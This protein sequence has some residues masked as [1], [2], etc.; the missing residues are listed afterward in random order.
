[1]PFSET[2]SCGCSTVR[3]ARYW[4]TT[5]VSERRSQVI[6]AVRLLF[7]RAQLRHVLLLCP[8]SLITN[9]EAEF[10]KWAPE[11]GV[12]VLS[13]SVGLREDA[14]RVVAQRRHVIL[15]NYE[16][17]R[18]PPKTLKANPP[19]L[20][21]ADEAHRLRK[22]SAKA[23]AGVR[24]L[25]PKRFWALTGTPMERDTDDLA[26][27]LSLV[28]PKRFSAR[29]AHLHPSSLR[30]QARPYVLRRRKSEV[31]GDLP[32]VRDTTERIELTPA[33][34]RAYRRT[35]R[36]F[37]RLGGDGNELALLTRLR[38]LC[39]LDPIT[40]SS[41]KADRIIELLIRIRD[42][43]EKAVVFAYLLGPPTEPRGPD[44][45]QPRPGCIP[46]ACR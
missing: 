7:H 11:L 4:P 39:D 9:W 2:V 40:G 45:Q 17:M 34:Q 8:K 30:A 38:E 44:H 33:Q 22:R 46:A 23:T 21:V 37:R 5:W 3:T 20:I 27:L 31:L 32:P 24:E 18:E 13:P 15:T 25:L 41:A 29:D 16:Q 43:G 1:M 19:D 42:Q 26:T 12:A 28:E 14:W 10:Q 6:A 35:I 36:E